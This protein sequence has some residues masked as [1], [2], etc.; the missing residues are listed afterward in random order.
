MRDVNQ[1]IKNSFLADL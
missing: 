1:L